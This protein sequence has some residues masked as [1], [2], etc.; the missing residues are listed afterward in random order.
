M[1]LATDPERGRWNQ[2]S[3]TSEVLAAEYG[4][5]DLDGSRPR[6]WSFITASE[7][8]PKPDAVDYR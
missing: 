5:N 4:V 6:A 7:K 2:R 1:A 8:E 3:S